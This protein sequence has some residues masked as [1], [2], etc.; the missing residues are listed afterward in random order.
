MIAMVTICDDYDS[1]IGCVDDCFD[2]DGNHDDGDDHDANDYEDEIEDDRNHFHYDE[3]EEDK[4][5]ESYEDECDINMNFFL[6]AT[7][8]EVQR[9][10]MPYPTCSLRKQNQFPLAQTSFFWS[11]DFFGQHEFLSNCVCPGQCPAVLGCFY[12]GQPPDVQ[13]LPNP[14]MKWFQMGQGGSRLVDGGAGGCSVKSWL[15][16]RAFRLWWMEPSSNRRNAAKAVEA[17]WASKADHREMKDVV[18]ACRSNRR[19]FLE[20]KT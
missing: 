12:T 2:D 9:N 5:K 19:S 1:N 6:A 3:E 7:I 10:M 15:G 4:Q 11:R 20:I 17:A 16:G 14:Q 18:A 8:P 13:N